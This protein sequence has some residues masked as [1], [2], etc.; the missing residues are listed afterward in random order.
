[1]SIL[2]CA[3][4]HFAVA[5]ARRD[6]P[7]LA[8][9]PLIVLD[10]DDRVFDFSPKGA[11]QGIVP[12]LTLRI[13]QIRCPE[14][15]LYRI[16]LERCRQEFEAFLEI[17]EQFSSTVE[18]HGWG[19]AYVEL[20][21][22][23][24]RTYAV[25]LCQESGRLVRQA[26]GQALQPAIGW[27]NGKFTACTAARCTSPGHLLPVEKAKEP[28]FLQP[29]SITLLPLPKDTIDHLQFLGLRT[30]GQYAALPTAAVWQRFGQLGKQAHLLAQGKDNRPVV[31]RWK[32]AGFSDQYVFEIP[33]V[34]RDHVLAA[35]SHLVQPLSAELQRKLRAC[36]RLRLVIGLDNGN[37]VERKRDF[38]FAVADQGLMERALQ[39]LLDDMQITARVAEVSVTLEQIQDAVLQ[40]LSLFPDPDTHRRKLQQI[41]SYLAARFGASRLWQATLIH[42]DAPLAEW[43][44]ANWQ[45]EGRYDKVIASR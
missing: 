8:D 33:T 37:T 20:D 1:V 3:I 2:Y 21:S 39:D 19:A 7:E 10:P 43:R 17:L 12:G 41:Q 25:P 4:P 34:E 45:N 40:Q 42:P 31:S 13:A 11:Q 16:D 26:L 32:S 27:D 24:D 38:I 35:A 28:D 15:N 14:A 9:G 36:G 29:L 44:I 18:P 22:L 5:L 30:L 23:D 6:H